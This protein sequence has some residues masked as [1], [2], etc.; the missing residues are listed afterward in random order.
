MKQKSQQ[1]MGI[2]IE[3]LKKTHLEDKMLS[4]GKAV[5]SIVVVYC[6][7]VLFINMLADN[8]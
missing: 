6:I 5:N 1:N 2:I 8:N 7:F 3:P 4:L